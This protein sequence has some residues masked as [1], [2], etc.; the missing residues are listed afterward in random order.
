VDGGS[1][2]GKIEGCSL[3]RFEDATGL[4][5][6]DRD[7]TLKEELPPISQFLVQVNNRIAR[8]LQRDGPRSHM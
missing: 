4:T 7:G 5:L 1:V 3:K 6:T 8:H 2:V